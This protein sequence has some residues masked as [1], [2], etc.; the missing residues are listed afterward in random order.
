VRGTLVFDSEGNVLHY[1]LK[2]G[3]EARRKT[4][5]KYMAYLIREGYFSLDDGERG[6]GARGQ[7]GNVVIGRMQRG[8]LRMSKSAAFR[9]K[10]RVE[11]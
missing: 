5:A 1:T 11:V 7:G 3:T 9:H 10:R 8:V 6:L 4:L 2:L